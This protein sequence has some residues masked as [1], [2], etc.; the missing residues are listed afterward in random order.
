MS[1]Y[2]RI[3]REENRLEKRY[4][5]R[6]ERCI[7]CEKFFGDC[8]NAVYCRNN[9]IAI[10]RKKREKE[11][12]KKFSIKRHIRERIAE[13][14]CYCNKHPRNKLIYNIYLLLCWLNFNK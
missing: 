6:I 12:N 14:G 5:L 13:L 8:V 2:R 3:R 4:A 10:R 11:I 1:E 7:E 9:R